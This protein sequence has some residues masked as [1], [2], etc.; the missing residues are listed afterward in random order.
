MDTREK[1]ARAVLKE[2]RD[3]NDSVPREATSILVEDSAEQET[4]AQVPFI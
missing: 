1:E 4:G 2:T 3:R